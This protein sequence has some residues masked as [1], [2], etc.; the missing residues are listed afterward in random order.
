MIHER[1]VEDGK[2]G[3]IVFSN[4]NKRVDGVDVEK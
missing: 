4:Q 1:G 2:Q 3:V